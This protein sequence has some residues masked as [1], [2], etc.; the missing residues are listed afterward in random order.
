MIDFSNLEQYRENNRIEAKKALGG[1]PHSIWETYSA[2]ANTLGGIILLGVEE[3][4]DHSLH[5]IDLPDPA[6]LV[7]EFWAI[8]NDPARTSVNILTKQHV[9]IENVH[10]NRIIVIT[11]PR[12]LRY[13]RPVYV[14]GNLLTG[15]YRRSGE[16]DYHCTQEEVQAMLRDAA[17]QTQDMAVLESLGLD[18]LKPETIHRYRTH[19]QALRIGPEWSS[20]EDAD[21][22]CKAGAAGKSAGGTVHPTAAGLLLFGSADEIVQVFPHYSLEYQAQQA[23]G[24]Q[25]AACIV[26]SSGDWSG[27]LYDFYLQVSYRLTRNPA[28]FFPSQTGSSTDMESVCTA[29][30]EALANCLINADYHGR[31]G[32]VIQRF[33][34]RVIF[35]NPGAFRIDIDT[36]K[37]GG[38]SD[39]R[40]AALI[41]L[42]H[43][44]NASEQAGSGIPHIYAVW[45]QQGW[46]APA[47]TE[48]YAPDRTTLTLC[49]R[50]GCPTSAPPA[51]GREAAALAAAQKAAIIEYLTYHICA[52]GSELAA[53]LGPEATGLP[54]L[55]AELCAAEILAQ[56]DGPQEPVYRLRS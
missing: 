21:F 55:L 37:S 42:F 13:D 45:Q 16:G 4:R 35:S 27:N 25:Q 11:V 46:S 10:G 49:F 5:P 12:A 23:D 53:F 17:V 15:T 7:R 3:H 19:V 34:D 32:V 14:G 31:Q 29:L 28:Q 33:P 52:T 20:L 1:L 47:I 50:N 48:E 30:R 54:S 36:A 18:V 26:S 24:S 41:R 39:P 43:L 38:V 6:R 22:L 9:Q 44:V 56:E 2:F 40:N 8:V 51:D